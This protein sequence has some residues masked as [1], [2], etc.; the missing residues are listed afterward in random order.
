MTTS[1]SAKEGK[2]QSNM[3][4]RKGKTKLQ[5]SL[6]MILEEINQKILAKKGRVKNTETGSS[7]TNKKSH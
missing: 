3:L 2:W 7:N 5:T 4:W 6:T 1:E